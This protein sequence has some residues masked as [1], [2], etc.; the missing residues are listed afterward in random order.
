MSGFVLPVTDDVALRVAEVGLAQTY[1]ALVER[2]LDRLARWERWAETPAPLEGTRAW[3]E[4]RMLAFAQG[5]QVPTVI[6]RRGKLVGSC[7]AC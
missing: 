3:L 6:L 7:S 5:L 2:N 4:S 1:H